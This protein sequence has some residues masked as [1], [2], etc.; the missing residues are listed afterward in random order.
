[1]GGTIDV[2]STPGRGTA[3][4]IQLP[5]E[6]APDRVVEPERVALIEQE[7]NQ[8]LR[9]LLVED[10][11]T[12]Q[13]VA[14]S[15]LEKFGCRVDVAGNGWEGVQAVRDLSYDAVLMDMRM[16]EMDGPTAARAIR[17]LP[18]PMRNVPIIALTA[19]A[20]AH[21]RE[22]C[23][24][25]GMNDFLAKPFTATALRGAILAAVAQAHSAGLA[26]P[27]SAPD[28]CPDVDPALVGELIEACSEADAA[29]FLTMFRSETVA[30][31]AR[32]RNAAAAGDLPTLAIE[33]HSLKGAAST[34][35]LSLI[36][37]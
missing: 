22:A 9:I 31:V 11:P 20:F 21:D 25:A 27:A 30:R 8:H 36:H 4:T 1:M 35:C 18:G 23:L 29:R 13:L 14:T 12:N 2:E 37:I 24:A 5:L 32:M 33:A 34:F 26:T 3:F 15:M 17:A 19:N 10:N 7:I 28:G 6:R 16:P